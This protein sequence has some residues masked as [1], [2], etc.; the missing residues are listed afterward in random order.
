M[1]STW[2]PPFPASRFWKSTPDPAAA[3]VARCHCCRIYCTT[4]SVCPA[5]L[6]EVALVSTK[7]RFRSSTISPILFRRRST[8]ESSRSDH[9]EGYG[10]VLAYISV[11]AVGIPRVGTR[12]EWG[13]EERRRSSAVTEE[14]ESIESTCTISSHVWTMALIKEVLPEPTFASVLVDHRLYSSF[15]KTYLVLRLRAL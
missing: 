3:V 13:R 10:L 5:R 14:S 1:A 2:V 4:E 8:R 6:N 7:H 12:P 11:V 9:H 15:R